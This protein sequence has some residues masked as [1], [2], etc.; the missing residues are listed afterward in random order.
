MIHSKWLLSSA[1]LLSVS[2]GFSMEALA[3]SKVEDVSIFYKN[4]KGKKLVEEKV[5]VVDKDLENIDAVIGTFTEKDLKALEKSKDIIV[6]EKESKKLQ[7]RSTQNLSYKNNK[8][9][10][11][12]TM[13]SAKNA[14][15]VGLSGKNVK[16]GI[17]DTEVAKHTSLP[18]VKRVTFISDKSDINRD[19]IAKSH[20]TF[21]AGIIAA[22]PSKKT[23]VIGISPGVS[24]YN[25]NING[26]SG[27]DLNDFMSA[28]DY[29]IKQKIQVI[30]IS[31]GISKA[32]LL[33]PGEKLKESP[34]YL[35]VKKAQDAGILIVAASGN[36]GNDVDY[37]AAF[38]GV[39]AVGAVSSNRAITSFSN[40]GSS[41]DFV[42]PGY[43]VQSLSYLGNTEFNSGTSFSAP[44][45]TSIIALYK[46]QYPKESNEK[47]IQRLK[48]SAVDLGE[49]GF[50]TTY[51]NGLASFPIVKMANSSTKIAS[52][53]AKY[54]KTNT[55]K[56][57]SIIA[58]MERN[59]AI[60]YLTE[61][62][63]VYTVYGDLS[64][65][66]KKKVNSYR[67]K[68]AST[69]ISSSAKSS[70]VSATN[71]TKL[72]SKKTS[73][74]TFK[75]KLKASTVKSSSI[76]MYKDGVKF[77]GI[78]ASVAKTGSS[79]TIKTTKKLTKGIYYLSMDTANYRSTTNKK[80][81]PYIVKYTV[82]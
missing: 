68:T 31:M 43:N 76:S 40:R 26:K 55:K 16:V 17:I 2:F 44:H 66:Q 36:Y 80:V 77:T 57:A 27:A 48:K 4:E 9:N 79:I 58:K 15:G 75:T 13:V 64:S 41:L 37:P 22:Q 72:H 63:P 61:F 62:T 74:I 65:N 29:A 32:A 46:Q 53:S 45:V 47:I 12:Q 38:D 33:S 20:G 54:V 1:L 11:N 21:V 56:I 34:L 30:N 5:K 35:A 7:I 51:G 19:P 69:V 81:S 10:W 71:L 28:M 23:N 24:L 52:P 18:S 14:W 70:R 49:K 82:K 42:A 78:K 73:K 3:S 6:V 60:N 8:T 67:S 50:D 59:K 25:I 39:I